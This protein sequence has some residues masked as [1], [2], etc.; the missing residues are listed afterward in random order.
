MFLKNTS[1][2]H[3][4]FLNTFYFF[5]KAFFS[6]LFQLSMCMLLNKPFCLFLIFVRKICRARRCFC[7]HT[8]CCFGRCNRVCLNICTPI[9]FYMGHGHM[10]FFDVFFNVNRFYPQTRI[11]HRSKSH[12]VSIRRLLIDQW[13]IEVLLKFRIVLGTAPHFYIFLPKFLVMY[14]LEKYFLDD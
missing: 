12:A 6:K 11:L 5:F 1:I 10:S 8:L 14:Y 2:Q 4:Q 13:R 7:G 3:C 9:T